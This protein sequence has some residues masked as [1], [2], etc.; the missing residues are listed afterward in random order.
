MESSNLQTGHVPHSHSEVRWEGI[1]MHFLTKIAVK[2][3]SWFEEIKESAIS[4]TP[5]FMIKMY[6]VSVKKGF[7]CP[8]FSYFLLFSNVL[9]L[10]PII[11]MVEHSWEVGWYVGSL[12]QVDSG[13][14][15]FQ[16]IRLNWT[17]GP[18]VN[19]YN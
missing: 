18:V 6:T 19:R 17:M 9:L 11:M 13:H 2:H 4:S 14:R 3:H 7:L 1:R 10:L 5:G 8:P 16:L 12:L 15:F